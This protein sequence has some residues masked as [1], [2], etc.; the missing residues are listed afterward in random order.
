MHL[1]LAMPSRTSSADTALPQE[2]KGLVQML[3]VRVTTEQ[4]ASL[5]GRD[6]AGG[7]PLLRGAAHFA[8]AP[9]D[10]LEPPTQA[11]GRPRS[12]H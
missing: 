8:M 6:R 12:V 7:T 3:V 4:R 1:G 2:L 11:L 5:L 9:P 10:G